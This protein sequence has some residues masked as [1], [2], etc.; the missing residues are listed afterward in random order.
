M[1]SILSRNEPSDK[2]GTIQPARA[3]LLIAGIGRRRAVVSDPPAPTRRHGCRVASGKCRTSRTNQLQSRPPLMSFQPGTT[4][5]H[6][7]MLDKIGQG[8]M[9]EVW[10]AQTPRWIATSP[11]RC[12]RT[13]FARR[14]RPAGALSSGKRS[15]GV[16]Q[17]PQHRRASTAWS[18]GA[19][20]WCMEL[21][22]GR[23]WRNAS[24]AGRC[25]WTRR[26][27]MPA[28][29]RRRWR[30]RTSGNR[31]SRPEAGQRQGHAPTAWSRC[32]TSGWRR[33]SAGD[34]GVDRDRHVDAPTTPPAL[35]Q[36][37][38]ILGTAAYM[39]PEQARGRGVDRRADIWAFGCV[40]YEML[41]GRGRSRL[42]R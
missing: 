26:C 7:R 27:P 5:L 41:T 19:R 38:M 29:S 37:G 30:P 42:T 24:R 39:S 23:R 35:T 6:Y 22:D 14:C 21:V 8:G 28:R 16:A 13:A 34:A 25:R 1:G 12:C 4:L 36:A 10:R 40:L 9:G 33:R 15:A 2:P 17:S 11:S 18:D 31:P 3:A 20:R 32:S